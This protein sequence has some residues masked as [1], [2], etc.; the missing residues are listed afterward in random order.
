MFERAEFQGE[1][2]SVDSFN[3]DLYHILENSKILDFHDQLIRDRIV[4]GIRDHKLSDRLQLDRSGV[5][6]RE[7]RS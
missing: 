3:T 6:L 2:E 5:D 4:V 1:Y 7:G